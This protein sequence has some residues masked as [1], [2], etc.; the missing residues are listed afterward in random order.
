LLSDTLRLADPRAAICRLPAGSGFIFRHYDHPQ[1]ETL[2]RELLQ[3]CR[4]RRIVF[5]LAGDWQMAVRIQAGGAH[6]PETLAH[7][8]RAMRRVKPDALVTVAAHDLG[9]LRRA[10]RFGADAVL[11]SPVF[12]TQSHPGG[13]AL[14]PVRFAKLSHAA[15]LPV[16]AL[17]G[18]NTHNARRLKGG[19]AAGIAA[20]GAL[21]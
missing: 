20:I 13:R 6:F 2:A 9:A 18:V 19:G 4:R 15:R 5:L 1:R 3:L 17:G 16:L 14:G 8:A 10:H 21:A 11:L 12:A 7:Q